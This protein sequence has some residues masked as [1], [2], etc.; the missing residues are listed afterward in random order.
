MSKGT[1]EWVSHPRWRALL[2]WYEYSN[3]YQK[4]VRVEISPKAVK[5]GLQEAMTLL[6]KWKAQ[7]PSPVHAH[8]ASG[9]DSQG[10]ETGE[11]SC[12]LPLHR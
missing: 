11:G 4:E 8:L 3:S 10:R 5:M 7:T 2:F 9:Q 12:G 6:S 1:G